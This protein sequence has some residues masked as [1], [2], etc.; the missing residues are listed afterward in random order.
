MLRLGDEHSI[1][2]R[3]RAD[4]GFVNLDFSAAA[5]PMLPDAGSSFIANRIL[6]SMN[7]A[8]F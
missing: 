8:L 2:A 4:V 5:A 6:C 1:G 3:V 7:H